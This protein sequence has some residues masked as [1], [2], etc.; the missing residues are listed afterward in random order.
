M[1]GRFTLKTPAADLVEPFRL[2]QIPDLAPRYN[3]APSQP[4]AAVREHAGQRELV[5]LRWG[6]VPSWAD[7]LK[8]G[9]KLIN[10]RSETADTK[11]SFRSAF[12]K[13]RCLILGDGFYEW[14]KQGSAKQPFYVTLKSRGPWAFAGLW[15]RWHPGADEVQSCTILT[16]EANPLIAD[17]HE[18]MPVILPPEHYDLWLDDE[19]EDP[20]VL[21]DLLQPFDPE[22]LDVYPVSDLVNSP[23]NDVPECA[24]RLK[25]PPS[26]LGLFG[27]D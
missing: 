16:T 26:Q 27:D 4:V 3:V 13:R 19:V 2:P 23:R 15:E 17:I 9:Y 5:E 21:K 24:E 8:I 6:L 22:L 7:D 14:Q 11:P 12:R 18:R 1:C 10:A 25:L 20:K